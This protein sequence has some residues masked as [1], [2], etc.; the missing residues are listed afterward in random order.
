MTYKQL[1]PPRNSR[2]PPIAHVIAGW[3]LA[4]KVCAPRKLNASIFQTTKETSRR[5]PRRVPISHI[6][7]DHV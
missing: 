2:T 5:L 7:T 1:H 4:M 3:G 6:Q